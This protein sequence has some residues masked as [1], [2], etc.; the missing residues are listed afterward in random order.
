[1]ADHPNEPS[2]PN[3]MKT[4]QRL[5][6]GALPK[7]FYAQASVE[8]GPDGFEL[9]LDGKP[10]RTPAKAK[11]AVGD[12]E[13]AAALAAEWNGLAEVIDPARMPLTRIVNS[14]ID[15][16]A[17][18]MAP[19]RADIVAH[20]GTDMICYR[21]TYPEALVER[22]ARAWSPLIEW[23]EAETGARLAVATGIAHVPQPRDALDR[24]ADLVAGYG[25]LEL[26][27]LHT[28]TTLTG[29]A[30]IA[31]AVARRRVTAEEA[32]RLAHVEEDWQIAQWGEDAEATRRRAARWREMEAAALILSAGAARE[33]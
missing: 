20:A 24:I 10:A 5:A 21:V 17:P 22:Q 32:W 12:R 13:V 15:G 1:M 25:P 28:V 3:S 14:A 4:A 27:A 2:P 18:N 11:V 6:R 16:V 29:S 19:V 26:A 8:E 7:R 9:R 30:V 33:G 23:L 31:L